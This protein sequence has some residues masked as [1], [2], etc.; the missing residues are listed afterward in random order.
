MERVKNKRIFPRCGK[1]LA[2]P[3]IA[4]EG[5]RPWQSRQ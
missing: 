4:R 2:K 5:H 3:T 1:G